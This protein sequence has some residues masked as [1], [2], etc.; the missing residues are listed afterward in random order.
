MSKGQLISKISLTGIFVILALLGALRV[1]VGNDYNTYIQNAHELYVGGY[2]I[3][4]PGYD[5]IVK[6]LYAMAGGEQYLLI[7]GLFAFVTT[8]IFL[9]GIYEGSDSFAISFFLFMALGIFFRSFNTVRYYFALALTLYSL[10]Y[11]VRKEYI[12]FVLIILFAALFHKSVLVVIPLYLIANRP[13]NKWVMGALTLMSLGLYLLKDTVMELALKIYPTYQDTIYLTQGVGLREN[14][15]AILRCV[16]VMLL[17]VPFYKQTIATRRDNTLYFNMNLMAILMYIACSYLPLISRFGYYLITAQ[18]L[19][20]ANVVMESRKTDQLKARRILW[21][22]CIMG[23]LY[24]GSFLKT[25]DK[26]GI[27]VLPYNSWVMTDHRWVN[28]EE[29][30]IYSSRGVRGGSQTD[31]NTE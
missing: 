2:T 29:N 21:A 31:G 14:L 23:L 30:L 4:E 20:V 16:L 3:T 27:A 13:W 5:L 22:V 11:V 18:I 24:F 17:C 7:F 28:E 19:L 12:R 6:L 1:G 10:K 9:K 26:E 15:P 25:A 8:F